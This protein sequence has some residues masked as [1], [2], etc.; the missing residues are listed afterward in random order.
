[1]FTMMGAD[2]TACHLVKAAGDGQQDSGQ[3]AL[4]SPGLL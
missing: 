2:N 1:M 3:E 4:F